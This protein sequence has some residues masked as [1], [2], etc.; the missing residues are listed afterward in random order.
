PVTLAR[1]NALEAEL[2]DLCG[3]KTPHRTVALDRGAADDGV[4]LADFLVRKARI[5][6]GE[7]HQLARSGL[8]ARAPDGE[9][10][11]GVYGRAAAVAALGVD[12]DGVDAHRIELPFPPDV[13][14]VV[15]LAAPDPVGAVAR[16]QHQPFAEERAGLLALLRKLLPCVG[17]NGRAD[18]DRQALA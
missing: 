5:C 17:G 14:A 8:F 15:A 4:H 16:L 12:H 2:E 6:L 10:V 18:A 13:G 7:R 3:T 1:R 9:G 11:I